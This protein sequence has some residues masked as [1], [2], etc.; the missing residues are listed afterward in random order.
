MLTVFWVGRRQLNFVYDGLNGTRVF[1][2][3]KEMGIKLHIVLRA[4]WLFKWVF[5]APLIL[6]FILFTSCVRYY[7]ASATAYDGKSYV[8][9]PWV[10]AM[11]WTVTLLPLVI[12]LMGLLHQLYL[13]VSSSSRPGVQWAMMDWPTKQWFR[14]VEARKEIAVENSLL[15]V[16]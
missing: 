1:G 2:Y 3:L 5:T 4:Y 8:F 10:S 6:V 15:T 11:G 14:T 9:P 16:F 7:P 13:A 12:A